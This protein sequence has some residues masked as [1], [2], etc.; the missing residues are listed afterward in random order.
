MELLVG[1]ATKERVHDCMRLHCLRLVVAAGVERVVLV[2][3]D[4]SRDKVKEGRWRAFPD[5][6]FFWECLGRCCCNFLRENA[7]VELHFSPD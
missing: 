7:S 6:F 4:D 2:F 5:F 1:A 3:H